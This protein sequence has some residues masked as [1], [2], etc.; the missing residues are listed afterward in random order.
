MQFFNS[1]IVELLTLLILEL[2][3]VC[4]SL[5]LLTFKSKKVKIGI[6]IYI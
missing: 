3:L 2:D 5:E 6:Y 4:F 1:F